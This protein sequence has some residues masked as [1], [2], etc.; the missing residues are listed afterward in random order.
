MDF[1]YGTVGLETFNNLA[2]LMVPDDDDQQN[3]KLT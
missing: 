3:V 1:A 2:N